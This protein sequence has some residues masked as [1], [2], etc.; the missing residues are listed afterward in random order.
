MKQMKRISVLML[1]TVC[2]VFASCNP[3]TEVTVKDAGTL[4]TQLKATK[5]LEEINTTD[6]KRSAQWR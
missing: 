6:S 2:L 1:G 3:M 5:A 4:L